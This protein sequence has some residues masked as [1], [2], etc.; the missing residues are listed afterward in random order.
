M[1]QSTSVSA[2]LIHKQCELNTHSAITPA[3]LPPLHLISQEIGEMEEGG[4]KTLLN[5]TA[6]GISADLQLRAVFIVIQ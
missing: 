6:A 1:R 3:S 4:K 5:D 2:K